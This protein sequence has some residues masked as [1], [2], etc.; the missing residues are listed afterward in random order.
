[1][2][3][4][5]NN[6][7]SK[8]LR[9]DGEIL[10]EQA[11]DLD[12]GS[13]VEPGVVPSSKEQGKKD[14]GRQAQTKP[15]RGFRRYFVI[16]IILLGGAYAGYSYWLANRDYESTDDAYTDGRMIVVAPEVTGKIVSLDVNDNEFVKAGQPIIHI[17]DRQYQIDRESAEGQLVAAKAQLA[18]LEYGEQVARKN[19]PALLSQSKAQLEASKASLVSA[20]A[21][22]VKAEAD[23]KRQ[24]SLPKQATTQQEVD[25]ATSAWRQAQAQVAQGEAQVARSEAEVQQAEPVDQNIGQ[26]TAQVQ[27]QRGS[28][29]QA[30]AALDQALL[31][32]SR[33]VVVAPQDG[34][35]AKRN[36]EKGNYVSP[37]QQLMTI[38][39]PQIWVTA[40]FKE[41]QLKLMRPGQPVTI[42]VDAYPQLHL[43]GHVDSFQAGSGSKFQA[44]PPENATGNFVK[45]VQRV[46]VKI[47]VDKGLD[48]QI[49]LPLGIS[50]DP[51][52][53][54]Q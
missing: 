22:L 50:V 51:R 15:R 52:V 9:D 35:I 27:N 26:T 23:Y 53:K 54:V 46:P 20:Q 12:R 13:D 38:V 18:R 17:D 21:V 30:Q 2:L 41:T 49:P 19:F 43:E 45:I 39:S 33:V 31:N 6:K 16:A 7:G 48:P 3:D 32:L 29:E 1:M 47:L 24:Q 44:F 25:A 42:G 40:N 8:P 34:W 4:R 14:D 5:P 37:G 28:V 11:P 10:L 36:V